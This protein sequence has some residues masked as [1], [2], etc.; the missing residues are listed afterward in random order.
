MIK[1]IPPTYETLDKA[2]ELLEQCYDIIAAK[3]PCCDGLLTDLEDFF[4]G[5]R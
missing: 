2:T 5:R 3:L 1:E 4:E